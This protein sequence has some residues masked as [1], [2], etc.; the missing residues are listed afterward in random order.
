MNRYMLMSAAVLAA[1][2]TGCATPAP[3]M[4]G[5]APRAARLSDEGMAQDESRFDSLLTVHA[6]NPRARMYVSLA[7]EAYRRNDDGAL[8]SL[9]LQAATDPKRVSRARG[10]ALWA[11]VDTAHSPAAT[12]RMPTS[13]PALEAALVRAQYP[14]L[15][16]PDCDAWLQ[17]AEREAGAVRVELTPRP[18][19]ADAAPRPTPA[20]VVPAPAAAPRAPRELR[21]IPSRVHFGLNLHNLSPA[22]QRVLTALVDS[23]RNFPEVSITLEGH[24]DPRASVAYN[25][26]LS[27]RRA[28]SVRGFLLSRG[29]ADSRIS[30]VAKGKSQLETEDADVRS[31]ARNRRVQLRYFAPDGREIP[32]LQLLDD[33]QIEGPARRRV[34][35]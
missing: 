15:G 32:A 6:G 14:L 27:R 20:P 7:R 16:A 25:D 11:L 9:L 33:L 31:L 5:I 29:I 35:R 18:V 2:M 30:I 12:T 10:T 24:T 22:S 17:I 1:G 23:L 3:L 13:T 21:G 4:H 19:V 26:A 28:T 34:R 8:T